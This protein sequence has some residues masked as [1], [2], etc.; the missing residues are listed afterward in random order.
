MSLKHL[1]V[2]C[3][4]SIV[5]FTSCND[6]PKHEGVPMSPSDDIQNLRA[7]M[8][9]YPDSLIFVQQLIEAYRNEGDYASAIFVAQDQVKK[10]SNDAY[11]WNVLANL[12]F[13]N[14]DT[15]KAIQSLKQAI[16]IFPMPEYL[17]GLATLYAEIK[18]PEALSIADELLQGNN[19]KIRRDAF[20]IKG[21]YFNFNQ[22][23]QF[24]IK[25][26]DSALNID[27]T[28]MFAYREKAIA[29]YSMGLY[30]ESIT[31]LQ[32]AVALRNNFDEAY[33]W[34]GKNYEKLNDTANAIQNYETALLYDNNYIEA[35]TAL[36]K[37]K[38]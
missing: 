17:V 38:K 12:H 33:Y 15:T 26:L 8:L 23:P 1:I 30:P 19:S 21:L 16:Q 3:L 10:D 32:R 20:F 27:Y 5:F 7:N 9:K 14:G 2:P 36:S 4:I 28:Y 24:A 35:K 22:Q 31:V 25:E 6:E 34:L 11:F 13:E 18:N 37:L 29:L